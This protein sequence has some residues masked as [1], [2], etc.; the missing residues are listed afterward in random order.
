MQKKRCRLLRRFEVGG[1]VAKQTS[2]WYGLGK[3][4]ADR[5]EN[6]AGAGSKGDSDF[7]AR[8]LRILVAAAECDATFGKIFAHR[9]FFLEAT[10]AYTGQNAG[11]DASA[12]AAWQHPVVFLL[13]VCGPAVRC[14]GLGLNPDRRGI[15][16]LAD[17]GH[18]LTRLEG[19]QL[20]F[21]QIDHFAAEAET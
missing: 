6:G 15:A 5:D 2:R 7:D 20:Q 4:D 9:D 1:A 13:V 19:T 10:A 16:N 17:A 14:F 8:A 11:F 3:N 21:I 12:V 18:A